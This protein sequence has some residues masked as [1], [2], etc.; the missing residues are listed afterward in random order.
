MGFFRTG[1][2]WSIEHFGVKPDVI[3]FGKALTNGLNPLSG[4]WARE[5]LINP[6]VFPPGSTHSTFN[7]NPLGTAVGLEAMKMMARD[8]LRDHRCRRRARISSK[9]CSELQNAPQDNRR[10]RRPRPG[11]ARRDLRAARRLHAEQGA[12]RPHG[13][14]G[15]KGDL[16]HGGRRSA[17]CSTSAATTRTSSRSRRRSHHLRGDRSWPS[18]CSIS[19]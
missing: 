16:E 5:E 4:I 14:R 11:A 7:A 19:C 2:L 1:K 17:S 10:R 6:T 15:L 3:V 9:A 12:A 13:R 8:G 18:L